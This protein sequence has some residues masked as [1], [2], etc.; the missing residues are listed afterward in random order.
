MVHEK[1]EFYGIVET[2]IE[3]EDERIRV[4]SLAS[5]LG[6]DRSIFGVHRKADAG[7]QVLAAELR[8]G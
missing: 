1:P 2:C 3:T 7:H 8:G 5:A 6:E 4:F